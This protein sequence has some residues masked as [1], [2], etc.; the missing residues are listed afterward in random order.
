V[1]AAGL[2]D[3]GAAWRS[4]AERD[5]I[6]LFGAGRYAREVAAAARGRG[7]TVRGFLTSQPPAIAALD[8]LPVQRL[9]AAALARAPVWI[10]VFNREAHS[11]YTALGTLLRSLAPAARIVWPQDYYGWLREPLGWRYWLAP[12]GDYAAA[13]P[14]LAA[15]RALLEDA[16]SRSAFDQ[17]IELRRLAPGWRSPAPDAEVQ[18]LPRWLRAQIKEPLQFVDGGAYRGETL[19]ALAGLVPIASAW[20]FEPDPDNY[21][22]LTAAAAEWPMPVV[23]IPAGLGERTGSAPFA[24]GEGEGSRYGAGGSQRVPIVAL[25]GCL[26]NVPL[27]FVKLDVE[28]HELAALAGAVGT[29]RRRRPTL[30]IA[31]YHRWDDL[32]RIPQFIAALGLGYR[33]RLGLHGHNS[34]DSVYYAY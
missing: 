28:G 23:H 24:A 22:A 21:A 19:R 26:A 33:L 25:D 34:F 27:N 31:G 11:D 16:P 32:W 29:L 30:A 12:P 1:S 2:D 10:G 18:Y 17:V 13:T 14:E 6:Y 20:T 9:D 8:G 3:E 7:L 5:G 4:E 15:A